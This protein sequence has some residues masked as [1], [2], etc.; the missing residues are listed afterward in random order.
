MVDITFF[1]AFV[2]GL[3]AFFSPCVIP[4]VPGYISYLTGLDYK[5]LQAN[6][7]ILRKKIIVHS[8]CF[9]LGFS[10][11]FILLGATASSL[12]KIF[13]EYRVVVKKLG[14]ILVFLFALSFL[15]ILN[16]PFFKKSFKFNFSKKSISL[17]GSFLVGLTFAAGWTACIGPILASILFLA[18]D[19][20]TIFSGIAYLTLFSMGLAIPFLIISVFLGEFLTHFQRFT[21]QVVVLKKISSLVLL[22][23]S[24]KMFFF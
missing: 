24:I 5:Q 19:T 1:I 3:L 15:D 22:L 10:V 23:I 16:I 4:I 13:I 7:V 12:G 17:L 18:S 6:P 8:L 11:C 20:N 9:V 14:A 2:A 21:K